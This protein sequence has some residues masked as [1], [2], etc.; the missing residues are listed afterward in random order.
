MFKAPSTLNGVFS[1]PFLP[2]APSSLFPQEK[3]TPSLHKATV[4]NPPHEILIIDFEGMIKDYEK[5][6]FDLIE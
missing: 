4:C 3:T 6:G 2:N 1:A 5:Y